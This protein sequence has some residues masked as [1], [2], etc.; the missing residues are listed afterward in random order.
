MTENT[1]KKLFQAVRY[2]TPPNIALKRVTQLLEEGTDPNLVYYDKYIYGNDNQECLFYW[3][4]SLLTVAIMEGHIHIVKKL[5]E[6]GARHT[7]TIKSSECKKPVD[8]AAILWCKMYIS[9]ELNP[10][11]RTPVSCKIS[12]YQ[13][14]WPGDK[15]LKAYRILK[16]LLDVGG[17]VTV[18][19]VLLGQT[20]KTK[21][22][23]REIRQRKVDQLF[24]EAINVNTN[25]N[26][27]TMI[28]RCE[29]H[30][31]GL[32]YL[33]YTDVIF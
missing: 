9:K 4:C 2:G 16:Y 22:L 31:F 13:I 1:N 24:E 14:I 3:H 17:K 6:N 29:K 20:I 33:S 15:E 5:I 23:E 28:V 25:T 19:D 21:F 18:N 7:D 32:N 12:K 10:T 26:I 30:A 8:I 27:G 11:N